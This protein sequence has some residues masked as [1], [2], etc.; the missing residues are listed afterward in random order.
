MS[1][2]HVLDRKNI[3]PK[4]IIHNI[5]NRV[6]DDAG[7]DRYEKSERSIQKATFCFG[8]GFF[9]YGCDEEESDKHESGNSEYGGDYLEASCKYLDNISKIS[10]SFNIEI[11]ICIRG[12]SCCWI[13]SF[14]TL[15]NVTIVAT[16]SIISPSSEKYMHEI[17]CLVYIG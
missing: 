10:S 1:N 9:F 13:T 12:K 3:L 11:Y 14:E 5:H 2:C 17:E 6:D 8:F 16:G 4:N 15:S 7:N